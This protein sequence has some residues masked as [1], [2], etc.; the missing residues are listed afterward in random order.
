MDEDGWGADAP[1]VTRTQLEKVSSAYQP[2]KVNMRDL[3]SQ[4]PAISSF[5]APAP[6]ADRPDVVKGAYQPIGKVDIAEIRRQAGGSGQLKDDRPE[7]VKGSY[8]PVGK[9]DIAAIRARAQKPES[10]VSPTREPEPQEQEQE[11]QPSF[12]QRSAAFSQGGPLT[13]MPKPKVVNKFGGS[14]TFTGTRAPVPGGFEAKPAQATQVGAAGRTFADQG[15]KTPAQIWAEKKARERG[16]SGGGSPVTPSGYTGVPPVSEQKSG[17]TG[18]QSG[19][20]GKKW[21]PVETNKTGKSSISEQKTGE[22]QVEEETPSSPVGGIS[23][24]RDRFSGAAP[25]GAPIPSTFDRAPPSAPEPETS[26]KPNR[27][28]P[29]PGLSSTSAGESS[30]PNIP[31]PPAV[32][33]SPTP[34]TPEREH[35]PIRVAMPISKAAPVQDVHEELASPPATVPTQSLNRAA[36]REVED[37]EPETGPDPGR[38]A[39]Q[40]AAAGSMSAAQPPSPPATATMAAGKDE[41]ARAEFDYDAQEDNEISFQEGEILTDIQKL[42]PDWWMV[43]NSKGQQGLVPS[44]YLQLIEDDAPM[45]VAA[46]AAAPVSAAPAAAAAPAHSQGKTAVAM[47]DYEAGEDNEISFPEDAI[48]TN[49][50]SRCSRGCTAMLANTNDRNSPTRTGGRVSTKARSVCFRQRTCSFEIR[51]ASKTRNVFLWPCVKGRS[52]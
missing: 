24:I 38:F 20:S 3:A 52:R 13:S 11:K 41:R 46:P 33:R 17:N 8:E 28:V 5:N 32:P 25:M 14:G 50:V 18:W 30:G 45:P 37:D 6:P 48:I 10:A 27:G 42:D 15:G 49:I 29:I 26:T 22:P 34:E 35:S 21:G 43:T 39:A 44:N 2:T 19:Y 47:Y 40:A 16:A 51:V 36:T 31:P 23:S 4:K 7:T 12:S 9:V 1:P